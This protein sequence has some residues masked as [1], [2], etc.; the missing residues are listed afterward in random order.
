M[1]LKHPNTTIMTCTRRGAA[2]L[3]ELALRAKFPRRNPETILDGDVETNPANYEAG[4]AMKP[5]KELVPQRLPIYKN[6]QVYL[7]QNLRKEADFVNGMLATVAEYDE[8]T[9][10]LIVVTATGFRL[11]VYRWSNPR[12]RDVAPHYPVRPGYAATIMKFQ[13][14]SLPH[15]TVYLD[16]QNVPGAAYTALSRISYGTDYLLGGF[17]TK[18]HFT[19]VEA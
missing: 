9:Q 15:V 12:D 4:G 5:S 11:A 17:L 6:M 7:T 3:N 13:G 19:P 16:A 2:K 18:D 14:A 10:S 1:L 8:A